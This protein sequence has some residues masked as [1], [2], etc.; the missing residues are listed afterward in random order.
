MLQRTSL[1]DRD[2]LAPVL[3]VSRNYETVIVAGRAAF[4]LRGRETLRRVLEALVRAR[5]GEGP[6]A[7][8][9]DALFE[10]A[11]PGTCAAVAPNLRAQR[12]YAVL[13][14]LRRLGLQEVIVTS[15]EGYVI[16]PRWRVELDGS[17]SRLCA[18][19]RSGS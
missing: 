5:R 15:D 12:V 10:A 17:M 11:W 8:S 9:V 2:G 1:A 4:G 19:P 3:R 18:Q 13:S 16:D 14:R 7:C 6:T